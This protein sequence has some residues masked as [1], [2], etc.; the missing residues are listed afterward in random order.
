MATTGA[1]RFA[2][3]AAPT[4]FASSPA[5]SPKI[6]TSPPR[7]KPAPRSSSLLETVASVRYSGDTRERR[8]SYVG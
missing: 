4:A 6:A 3:N 5:K 1:K 8:W 7:T 2:A